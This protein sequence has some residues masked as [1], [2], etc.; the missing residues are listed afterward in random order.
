MKTKLFIAGIALLAMTTVASAQNQGAGQRP[1]NGKGNAATAYVDANNDGVCDNFENRSG[2]QQ[3]GRK[4]I[5]RRGSG[6][7]M[8]NGQGQRGMRQGRGTGNG[9]GNFVDA[10]KNGICDYR[11]T[12]PKK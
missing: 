4:G 6:D 12:T 9:N 7:G 2:N 11:E 1:M 10:D 5:N 8:G 3:A